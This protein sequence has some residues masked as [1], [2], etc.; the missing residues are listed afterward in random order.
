MSPK[1]TK[2]VSDENV[3]LTCTQPEVKMRRCKRRG[4]RSSVVFADEKAASELPDMKC[5]CYSKRSL[6][7]NPDMLE[8]TQHVCPRAPLHL[9]KMSFINKKLALLLTS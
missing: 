4:K 6:Y 1:T 3:R 8:V 2:S 5:V 9:I 7:Y